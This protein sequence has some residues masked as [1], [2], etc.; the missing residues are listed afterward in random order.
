MSVVAAAAA[1]YSVVA[2]FR[3]N[4]RCPTAELY[5]R[6]LSA[7]LALDPIFCSSVQG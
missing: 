1:V 6:R 3:E 2:S 5:M 7:G 4:L